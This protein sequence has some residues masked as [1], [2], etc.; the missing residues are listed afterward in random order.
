MSSR[1][2][3]PSSTP[4]RWLGALGAYGRLSYEIYLSHIFVVLGSV[5]I[6]KRLGWGRENVDLLLVFVLATSWAFGAAVERFIS[7]P[8]NHWLRTPTLRAVSARL[9]VDE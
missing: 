5:A 3:T 8:C 7:L 4:A 6:Y 9:G 1:S 2:A